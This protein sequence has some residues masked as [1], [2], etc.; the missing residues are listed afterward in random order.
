MPNLIQYKK[1]IQILKHWIQ[2]STFI[3][4]FFSVLLVINQS[5]LPVISWMNVYGVEEY[6]ELDLIGYLK[7]LKGLMIPIPLNLSIF[8]FFSVKIFGDTRIVTEWF[9]QIS[10]VALFVVPIFFRRKNI[11]RLVLGL[12]FSTCFFYA[13]IRIHVSNPQSYDI[14]FPLLLF[15][16]IILCKNIEIHK[17][18]SSSKLALIGFLLSMLD[19]LRPFGF[20]IVVIIC[21]YLVYIIK[22]KKQNFL[23]Y[24]FLFLPLAFITLPFHSHLYLNHK[25]LTMTNHSGF[26]I[27]RAWPQ[28][29]PKRNLAEISANPTR[30]GRWPNINTAEHRDNSNYLLSCIFQHIIK[31]PQDSIKHIFRNIYNFTTFEYILLKYQPKGF[32]KYW[33]YAL[34]FICFLY[35][36][37]QVWS[38]IK[39]RSKSIIINTEFLILFLIFFQLF[40]FALTESGETI[41]FTIGLLPFLSIFPRFRFKN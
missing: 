18:I 3:F 10:F 23:S 6:Q 25:Q 15:I 31:H 27:Q 13:S 40:I 20:L 17:E 12:I 9:Y 24:V 33:F 2:I 29:M 21:I 26:N 5:A 38:L 19:M 28:V 8:E 35:L 41:R 16:I 30:E 37:S 36:F 7:F 34:R 4:L 32:M 1:K 39:N 11:V 22:Q 14:I